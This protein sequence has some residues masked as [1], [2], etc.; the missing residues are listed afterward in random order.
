M[1]KRGGKIKKR[2][3]ENRGREG[4]RRKKKERKKGR[5]WEITGKRRGGLE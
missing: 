1:R 2:G 4:K 5:E 3:K